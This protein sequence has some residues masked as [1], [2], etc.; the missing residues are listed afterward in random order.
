MD[1]RQ[2][3]GKEWDAGWASARATIQERGLAFAQDFLRSKEQL[4]HSATEPAI[5]SYWLGYGRFMADLTDQG[6]YEIG[7]GDAE[8]GFAANY[9]SITRTAIQQSYLCGYLDG[10]GLAHPFAEDGYA[11]GGVAYGGTE[12]VVMYWQLV[13]EHKEEPDGTQV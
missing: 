9:G 8:H 3:N 5:Q 12:L 4:I 1:Q 2:F 6:W 7:Q 11:D 10:L 13:R